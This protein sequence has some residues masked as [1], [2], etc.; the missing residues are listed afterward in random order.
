MKYSVVMPIKDEADLLCYSLPAI[1]GL[2]PDEVILVM[3]PD[4]RCVEK[5][6]QITEMHGYVEKTK[7]VV[8]NES[9]DWRLRQAYARRKGFKLSTN[10]IILTVDVD[11]IVDEKVKKY[12]HLI[13]KNNVKLISFSEVPI[14][15]SLRW[16]IYT[17]LQKLGYS[18]AF[19][20]LYAFSKQAWLETENMDSAKQVYTSEDTH[21]VENL[22]KKYH[23]MHISNVKNINMRPK[24]SKQY[25]FLIGV[26][27]KRY[28]WSFSK[29]LISSFLLLRPLTILGYLHGENYIKGG[30]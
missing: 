7:I 10:D 8:I 15:F 16:F 14:H 9:C 21:L 22:K 20:G 4:Q 28:G 30:V 19:M 13:G 29:I 24:E 12:F 3:E 5:A 1:F 18:R 2:N 23:T 11:K 17:L 6:K 27:R 26:E 25:E